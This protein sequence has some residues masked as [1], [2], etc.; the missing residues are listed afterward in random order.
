MRKNVSLN[1]FVKVRDRVQNVFVK[2]FQSRSGLSA[3]LK[4]S[5]KSRRRTRLN[6]RL[7]VVDDALPDQ[8]RITGM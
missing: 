6:G 8:N 1:L 5:A 2:Y 3:V 4:I 7:V